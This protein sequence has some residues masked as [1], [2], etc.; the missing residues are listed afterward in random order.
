M[1]LDEMGPIVTIFYTLFLF[2]PLAT[3]VK[4]KSTEAHF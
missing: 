3:L 1:I 2:A 4:K